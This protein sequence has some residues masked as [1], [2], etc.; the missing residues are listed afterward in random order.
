MRIGIGVTE[1][2]EKF[3]RISL[4]TDV[5]NKDGVLFPR[6]ING[7]Y[8][9]ITRPAGRGGKMNLMW[10]TYSPDLIHWGESRVLMF[11]FSWCMECL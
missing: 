9:M 6:K 3:E 1:D 7:K 8:V 10:I 4:A 5:D 11:F 2:F